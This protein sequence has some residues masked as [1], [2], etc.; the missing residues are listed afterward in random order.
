MA[1]TS[2]I[3][4]LDVNLRVGRHVIA[5]A[6]SVMITGW[7][8]RQN[9]RGECQLS[10]DVEPP[11][12]SVRL[13]LRDGRAHRRSHMR[14]TAVFVRAGTVVAPGARRLPRPRGGVF[15]LK[16][17][18]RSPAFYPK[19]DEPE[20]RERSAVARLFGG[21]A[22]EAKARIAQLEYELETERAHSSE[23]GA[24]LRESEE[25]LAVAEDRLSLYVERCKEGEKDVFKLE[26]Q[27]EETQKGFDTGMAVAKRQIKLLED[28]LADEKRR[29][30]ERSGS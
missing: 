17:I 25:K 6:I 16:P 29:S 15:A 24:K 4:I 20:P 2:R 8:F 9:R 22:K 27:L 26:R 5:I 1:A 10:R 14:T 19:A 13:T 21:G 28:M 11:P 3:F 23:L 7:H 18:G 12:L 30:D